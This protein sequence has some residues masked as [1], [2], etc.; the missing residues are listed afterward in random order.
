MNVS[1]TQ[2]VTKIEIASPGPNARKTSRS[3]TSSVAVP[4]QTIA[5]AVKTIGL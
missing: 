1:A 2:S 3:P 5:P 4:R